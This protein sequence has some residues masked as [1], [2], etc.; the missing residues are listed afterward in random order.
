MAKKLPELGNYTEQETSEL[1]VHALAELSLAARV[2]AV[3][4][5][6]NEEERQELVSHID[7]PDED[8]K[9]P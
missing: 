5:A 1:A 7:D 8:D 3:L 9:A 4:E 2:K 6:F